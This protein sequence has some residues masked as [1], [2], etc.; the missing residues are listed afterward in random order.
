MLNALPERKRKKQNETEHQPMN[1]MRKT[2]TSR[3]MESLQ[4]GYN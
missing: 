1:M 3:M 2:I 4:T